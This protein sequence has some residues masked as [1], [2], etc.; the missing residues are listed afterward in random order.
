MDAE[1]EMENVAAKRVEKSEPK[2]RPM[3]SA[4]T[5]DMNYLK[6]TVLS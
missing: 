3:P 4:A 2:K 5:R 1:I 6:G